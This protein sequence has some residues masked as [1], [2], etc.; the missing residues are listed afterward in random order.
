MN[1]QLLW[2]LALLF[3][4]VLL[5]ALELKLEDLADSP[6]PLLPATAKGGPAP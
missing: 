5:F 4:A 3:G 6:P 1:P 2:V